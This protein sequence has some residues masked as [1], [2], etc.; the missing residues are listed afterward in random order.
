MQL[1]SDIAAV[2]T[3]GASG[4]GAATARAL[5]AHGVR[6]TVFDMS[7]TLGERV[8]V[9]IGGAFAQVDVSD[10]DSVQEG[11]ARARKLNGQERILV[12][13]AGI[14]LGAKIISRRND[15]GEIARFP[16]ADFERVIQVNLLGTFRCLAIAACGMAGLEPLE[17]GERG[18][19]VNTASVA[20]VEGQIGQAAYAAS[21]AGVMGLTLPVARDLAS[22]GIRV[23]TILPGIMETAMMAGMP[24][25]VRSGLAA[26]V[27]F[28][29]R[30][31]SPD[32]F[33]SLA[34]EFCRN[35]YL[36]GEA[37]RLDGAIRMGPR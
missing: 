21:K 10:E 18:I 22:E 11:F 35:R 24:E 12:N 30:L 23:N 14:V 34:L 19:I 4:L 8:A 1:S 9:D 28:P 25:K 3:G 17:D 31:G 5:A 7:E 33:A 6:V 13:C 26:A 20:A 36:N 16:S 32:E 2:V 29:A 15:T 37:V 27:P